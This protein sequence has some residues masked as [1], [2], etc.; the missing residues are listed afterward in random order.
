M[1]LECKPKTNFPLYGY[2]ECVRLI[3]LFSLSFF[4]ININLTWKSSCSLTFSE[5]AALSL[6]NTCKTIV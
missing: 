2:G 3:F 6:S 5:D 1:N 4:G